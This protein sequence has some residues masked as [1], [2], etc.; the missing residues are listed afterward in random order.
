MVHS[1]AMGLDGKYY[2]TNAFANSIGVFNPKTR[3]WEPSIFAGV[4]AIY[5][6]TVRIDKKGIVWF[7]IAANERVGR[8]DPVS[9]ESTLIDL[10]DA[11]SGGLAGGSMPYG[12]DINPA[13]GSIYTAAFLA[14]RLGGLTPIRSRYKNSIRR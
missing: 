1:L 11:E 2:T 13:D 3:E 6:H 8:V 9:K 5:P 7:T 14:T 10:P 12:I 4:R